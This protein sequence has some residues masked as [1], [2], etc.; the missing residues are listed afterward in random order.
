MDERDVTD[1]V[2]Q[3]GDLLTLMSTLLRF[4]G[5]ITAR[6]SRRRPQREALSEARGGGDR[7]DFFSVSL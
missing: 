6:G 5:S 7:V 3:R 1:E 2:D 4:A